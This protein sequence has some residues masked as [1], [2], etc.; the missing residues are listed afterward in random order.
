MIKAAVRLLFLC[1]VIAAP[2]AALARRPVVVELFTAQGCSSC[3]QANAA[4]ARLADRP[5]LLVLTWSVDYWDYLGWKDT[6][7]KPEFTER[8]KAYDERFGKRDVYTP[9]VIVDGAAQVSGGKT[10][11][12]DDMV[13]QA[14]H[15]RLDPPQM[16]L[17]ADGRVAVGSGRP[18]KGGGEVWLI[19]YDPREQDVEVKD[20][21][22]RGKTLPHRNVVRQLV[23][24]GAWKGIP[25]VFRPPPASEDGLATAV[26]LQGAKGGRVLGVLQEPAPPA[27]AP[28][29]AKESAAQ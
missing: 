4:V 26:L 15:A 2:G 20:G 1:A 11:A 16:K 27:A 19:R 10:A 7:A 8:Q 21:D 6:F 24:L 28:P 13:R 17:R 25:V 9:Q 22:N 5:N 3:K 12:I 29:A 23:R 14:E 18:P